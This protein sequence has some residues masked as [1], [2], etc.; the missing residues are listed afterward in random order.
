MK[1]HAFVPAKHQ[2]SPAKQGTPKSCSGA[3]RPNFLACDGSAWKRLHLAFGAV[4]TVLK[5]VLAGVSTVGKPEVD[6][7]ERIQSLQ[8]L[9][10]VIGGFWI[11]EIQ[12][13][14]IDSW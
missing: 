13:A 6:V 14:K 5:G 11:L 1:P 12:V 2:A 3:S 9:A 4:N 10:V 7:S 8:Q